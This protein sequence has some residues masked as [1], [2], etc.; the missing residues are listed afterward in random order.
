MFHPFE[1]IPYR[2]YTLNICKLLFIERFVARK[3]SSLRTI[4]R[5]SNDS[6]KV[7]QLNFKWSAAENP[8][9]RFNG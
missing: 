1:F 6:S 8:V 3:L 4:Q 7:E 2:I 9:R 5:K